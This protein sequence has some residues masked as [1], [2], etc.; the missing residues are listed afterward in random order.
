MKTKGKV[1]DYVKANRKGSRDAE[2]QVS[3][4][5]TAKTKVHKSKKLYDR[6]GQNWKGNSDL[7]PFT[8]SCRV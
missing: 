3:T 8:A 7:F 6:K 5:W 1:S 2:Y 4:G